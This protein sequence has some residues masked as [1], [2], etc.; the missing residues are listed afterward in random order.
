MKLKT[1]LTTIDFLSLLNGSSLSMFPSKK[2]AVVV[3]Q[4]NATLIMH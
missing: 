2:I 4:N 3:M 1:D